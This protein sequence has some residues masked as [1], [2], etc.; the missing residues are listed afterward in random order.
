MNEK[1]IF[2]LK[3]NVFF[4]GL[5][6]FFTDTSTKMVYTGYGLY[7]A[8][9]GIT[10]LPASIIAGLLYDKVDSSAPFY[11][12]SLLALIAAVLMVLFSFKFR[13]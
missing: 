13:K 6:S 9:L 7:H 3:R 12:G 2:G 1:K 5:T 8:I 11:F 4:A 10:L